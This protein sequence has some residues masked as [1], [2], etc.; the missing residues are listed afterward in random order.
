[1]NT[2]E[3]DQFVRGDKASRGIFQGVL[4][5]DT[6]PDKPRLLIGNTEPSSKPA[7]SGLLF[8]SILKGAENISI[9][10]GANRQ[11]CLKTIL[12]KTAPAGFSA[13][14]NYIVSSY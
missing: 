14:D 3:I 8:S 6:L 11:H 5:V 10:S 12:T 2:K 9:R 1:M 4:S 13:R 7:A